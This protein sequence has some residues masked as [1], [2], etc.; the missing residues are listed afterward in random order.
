MR[1]ACRF[2]DTLGQATLL[3]AV[4]VPASLRM[5]ALASCAEGRGGFDVSAVIRLFVVLR[6]LQ[7]PVSRARIS[8]TKFCNLIVAIQSYPERDSLC[9]DDI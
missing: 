2:P 9:M 4:S 6:S 7:A 5:R 1:F 3:G 8:T